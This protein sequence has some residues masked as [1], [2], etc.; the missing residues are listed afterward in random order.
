MAIKNIDQIVIPPI[1]ASPTAALFTRCHRPVAAG[2]DL[3]IG[4]R[5]ALRKLNKSYATISVETCR[6]TKSQERF[7]CI[8]Q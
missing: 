2:H 8:A 4:S 6:K 1:L 5:Y 7:S 3:S